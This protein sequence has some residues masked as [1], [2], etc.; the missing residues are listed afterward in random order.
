M[1]KL[2]KIEERKMREEEVRAKK[3]ALAEQGTV[4]EQQETA[5]QNCKAI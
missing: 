3:S 4:K 1:E 5:D 2:T